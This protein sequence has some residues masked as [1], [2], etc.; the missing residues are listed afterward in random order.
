MHKARAYRA[1]Q[2][3]QT[4][5]DY[6]DSKLIIL[7]VAESIFLSNLESIQSSHQNFEVEMKQN[8]VCHYV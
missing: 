5:Y 2:W 7:V 4:Y 1:S 6:L 3:S 8:L